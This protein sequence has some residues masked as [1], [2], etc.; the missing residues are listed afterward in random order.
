MKLYAR[1]FPAAAVL[2]V[3]LAPFGCKSKLAGTTDEAGAKKM[4]SVVHMGDPRMAPQLLHGFH[5]IEAAAWR[6]THRQFSIVLRVPEGAAQKGGKLTIGL[7]VPP[8]TIERL[9]DIT[10]SGTVGG[11]ACAPQ[12]FTQPGDYG[13][14]CDVPAS[15][16]AGPT[17]RADFQLD[18]AIPPAPPDIRELGIVVLNIGLETK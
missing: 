15:A 1:I 12:T 11:A 7:T 4:F 6:W 18:K 10:L 2:A 14:H 5:G 9:K 8:V 13:Y 16:L 3:A 17:V